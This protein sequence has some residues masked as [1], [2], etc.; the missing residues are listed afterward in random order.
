MNLFGK[1]PQEQ[2]MQKLIHDTNQ[3]LQNL[4]FRIKQLSEWLKENTKKE[5]EAGLKTSSDPYILIEY[6]KSTEK[7]ICDV[8]DAYYTKFKKD[9]KE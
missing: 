6:L 9:F 1:E 4:R 5:Q 3:E 8:I 7:K 2:A